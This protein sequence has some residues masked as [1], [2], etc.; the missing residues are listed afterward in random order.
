MEREERTLWIRRIEQAAE[1]HRQ[2]LADQGVVL[3]ARGDRPAAEWVQALRATGSGASA[4]HRTAPLEADTLFRIVED[5]S[6][7]P[8]R[9]VA[10]AIALGGVTDPSSRERL[11]IAASTTAAPELT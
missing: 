6:G 1:I 4:D 5:P 11:R 7:D 8:G 3:P 10:A 9:R 2:A